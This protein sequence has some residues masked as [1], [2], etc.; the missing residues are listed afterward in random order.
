MRLRTRTIDRVLS[1][2]LEVM[3]AGW[4]LVPPSPIRVELETPLP[5]KVGVEPSGSSSA[6][7]VPPERID[8][9]IGSALQA[10]L[11]GTRD[12]GGSLSYQ[13]SW[14]PSELGIHRLDLV[15]V[16]GS[17]A[18]PAAVQVEVLGKLDLGKPVPVRF[19]RLHG[20]EEGIAALDLSAAEVKGRFDLEVTTAFDR[21]GSELEMQT[22]VGWVPLGSRPVTLRLE[23]GGP[24]RWALR[25]RV[26]SCPAACKPSEPQHLVVSGLGADHTPRRLEM[27]LA[28][29]VIPDPWLKCWWPVLAA[30]GLAA[31]AG[32]VIH[33]FWSPSRFA[34]RLGVQISQENDMSEGFFHSIRGTRGAGSGFYRDALIYVGDFQLTA[35]PGGALARLRA[36]R[37]QVRIRPAN[38]MTLWRQAQDNEWEQ[39]PSEETTVRSGV[40]YRNDHGTLF[41]EIRNR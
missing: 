10:E 38:G 14:T 41:F 13:G 29:E 21:S 1:A 30:L 26:G 5:L 33:G 19:G 20:G 27:P 34:S 17:P 23:S 18:A 31:L 11:R 8:V 12:A 22:A 9:K 32:F 6:P 40:I 39:V 7:R 15:P 3:D 37:N 16:G 36:H 24:R 25:L 35:K 28:V 4:R 2:G